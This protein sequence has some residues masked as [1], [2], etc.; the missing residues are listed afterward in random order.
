MTH[1]SSGGG[2]SWYRLDRSDL[3]ESMSPMP[4][5]SC[6]YRVHHD[7]RCSMPPEYAVPAW[8]PV[9]INVGEGV[10]VD[11]MGQWWCYYHAYSVRCRLDRLRRESVTIGTTA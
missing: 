1:A 6:D 9:R 3:D 5:R 2:T 4:S 8:D 10:N 11:Q 7:Q